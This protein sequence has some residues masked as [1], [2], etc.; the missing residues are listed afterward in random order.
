MVK[1]KNIKTKKITLDK[2]ARMMAKEFSETRETMATKEGLQ[3]VRDEISGLR[4]YTKTEFKAVRS[5]ISEL[6]N[7]VIQLTSSVD[8]LVKGVNDLRVEYSAVL[9]KLDRH[10]QWIKQLAEHAGVQLEQSK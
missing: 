6:Q 10:E 9:S 7:T 8:K 5:E 2:L 4:I 1:E 3:E